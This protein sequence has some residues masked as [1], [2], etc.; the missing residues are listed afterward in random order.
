MPKPAAAGQAGSGRVTQPAS[1]AGYHSTVWNTP[2][3]LRRLPAGLYAADREFLGRIALARRCDK[4]SPGELAS[5]RASERPA[6][7]LGRAIFEFS[8]SPKTAGPPG[9]RAGGPA[10]RPEQPAPRGRVVWFARLELGVG[11]SRSFTQPISERN[12]PN[13]RGLDSTANRRP[14][15]ESLQDQPRATR[16]SSNVWG[17]RWQPRTVVCGPTGSEAAAADV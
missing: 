14:R 12:S 15:P 3:D 7:G 17:C 13:R 5:A 10:I 16:T 8:R 6:H 4:W 11:G 1:G 9:W 2:A